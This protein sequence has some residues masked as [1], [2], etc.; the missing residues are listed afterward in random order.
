MH[1]IMVR[2]AWQQL[3]PGGRNMQLSHLSTHQE[4][5]DAGTQLPSSF[6]PLFSRDPQLLRLHHPHLGQI[7]PPQLPFLKIL[8]S[9]T[10]LKVFFPGA[11]KYFRTQPNWQLKSSHT[12]SCNYDET[13]P[14][15]CFVVRHQ[16]SLAFIVKL[17]VQVSLDIKSAR[18]CH[19][20][21]PKSSQGFR[22]QS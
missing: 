18:I 16:F 2:E 10:H 3:L 9:H 6:S 13:L 15:D 4:T 11:P 7:L 21:Y 17:Q 5:R 22:P 14:S 19:G 20:A 8:I 12:P 1:S